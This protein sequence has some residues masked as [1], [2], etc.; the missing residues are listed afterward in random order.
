MATLAVGLGG[1]C[2]ALAARLHARVVRVGFAGSGSD[3]NTQGADHF[4]P[5][6][7]TP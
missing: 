5:G 1:V 3:E 7:F 6:Y 2:P 4:R